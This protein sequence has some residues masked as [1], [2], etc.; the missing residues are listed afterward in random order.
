MVWDLGH[1]IFPLFNQ[2]SHPAHRVV[3][4]E[5]ELAGDA[6]GLQ[7]INSHSDVHLSSGSGLQL[8]DLVGLPQ[9]VRG[10]QVP[11][12]Q[13]VGS[14]HIFYFKN[15]EEHAP[16]FFLEILPGQTSQ[17]D[18]SLAVVLKNFPDQLG[19]LVN[20][21]K[22][23]GF[24]EVLWDKI[25]VLVEVSPEGHPLFLLHDFH[26]LPVLNKEQPVAEVTSQL[27]SDPVEGIKIRHGHAEVLDVFLNLIEF[28]LHFLPLNL[29][30]FDPAVEVHH[31]LPVHVVGP[32]FYLLEPLVNFVGL[33]L[34]GLCFADGV[35]LESVALV[36]KDV[37]H[38][39]G[40]Y[41]KVVPSFEHVVG[42]EGGTCNW[43]D[44]AVFLL[45]FS[46]FVHDLLLV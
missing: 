35:L 10:K 9:N 4:G 26:F 37:V 31:L 13:F 23:L 6:P 28:L 39:E 16:V 42:V 18:D 46:D 45:N 22:L 34:K 30:V 2:G 20:I 40:G 19:N 5:L 7:V 15:G 41:L 29:P 33:V 14:W 8:P 43:S 3:L 1:E 12:S 27:W 21:L 25:G 11:K 17:K 24:G 44:I 38:F 32:W 36:L